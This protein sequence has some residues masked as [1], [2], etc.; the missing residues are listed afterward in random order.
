V[1]A[2]KSLAYG[3]SSLAGAP[4]LWQRAFASDGVAVLMYH[5]VTRTSLS[6]TDWVFVEERLFR[7]QMLYLKRHC[8]VLPLRD[9]PAAIRTGTK[10]RPIVALTFDDGF[11]NNYGI[12]FPILREL[13]LPA[14]IFLATDFVDSDDT[15]WFC[16]IND[17]LSRTSLTRLAWDGKTYD[18][19]SPRSRAAAHARFQV[20][21]KR[22]KHPELLERVA[23]LV[24]ALGDRPG[25]AIPRG[26]VYRMLATPEI[27]EMAGMGLIEFGAHS[28]SHAILSG[29]TAAERK[30]EV[31]E[32]VAAVA[33]L[34]GSPCTLFAYPNGRA[35]DYG[36]C[37]MDELRG[38]N[39]TVA[40]TTVAG[41]NDASVPA[42]E[43]RR[44]GVGAGTSL[45][46]FKLLTHHV[47]WSLRHLTST[48]RPSL[49]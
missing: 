29:L 31:V 32:S 24:E 48:D 22:F 46:Q 39:I 25:K 43:M 8:Q 45:S 47:L 20:Q 11:Q 16:R 36:P 49:R 13:A 26:S 15:V 2:L 1:G 19:S 23:R 9:V 12:A 5:A 18:L 30:R 3:L 14:T 42:L 35:I 33:R 40:V 41:P 38:N 4:R 27:R 37:D 6:V 44:Y 34:T 17:A 21:L 7:Q 10:Q 28:C